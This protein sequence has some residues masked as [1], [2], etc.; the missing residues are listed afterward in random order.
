MGKNSNTILGENWNFSCKTKIAM[1]V[2][3]KY[4]ITF[5]K[6]IHVNDDQT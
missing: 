1:E 4:K 6:L 3:L 2:I 5:G